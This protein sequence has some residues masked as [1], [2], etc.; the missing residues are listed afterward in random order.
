M[1]LNLLPHWSGR[2]FNLIPCCGYCTVFGGVV[3]AT[4]S[5]VVA[6]TQDEKSAFTNS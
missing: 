2:R 5:D 4:A 1:R 3:V 6:T